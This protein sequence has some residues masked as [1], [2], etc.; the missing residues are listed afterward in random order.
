[1]ESCFLIFITLLLLFMGL[2]SA[3]AQQVSDPGD[4]IEEPQQAS[5][6]D[7]WN[8]EE[9]DEPIPTWFGMGFESRLPDSNGPGPQNSERIVNNW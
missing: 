5:N 1:M 4:L 3:L 7:S 6:I 8:E 2:G 9:E